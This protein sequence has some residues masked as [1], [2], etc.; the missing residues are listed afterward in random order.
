MLG[1]G[2]AKLL[3][4]MNCEREVYHLNGAHGLPGAFYL[5]DKFNGDKEKVK[6]KIE[7][8]KNKL[9]PGKKININTATAVELDELFG[10]GPAR[11]KLIIEGRPYEKIEDIMKVK[12]I[13]DVEY[14][15]IKDQITVK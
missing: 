2:G 6:E 9:P 8:A 1:K 14:G 11:A 5:L 13:K 10:I 4:E 7:T 15:K 3:D 12:G